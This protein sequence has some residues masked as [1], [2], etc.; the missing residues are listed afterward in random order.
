MLF[1]SL[2]PVD[3]R[4][5]VSRSTSLLSQA[6]PDRDSLDDATASAWESVWPDYSNTNVESTGVGFD[7]DKLRAR[8]LKG[9][10]EV[11]ELKRGEN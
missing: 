4:K 8:V 7:A 3:R 11:E 5:P 2:H 9:V 6:S 10:E 1:V